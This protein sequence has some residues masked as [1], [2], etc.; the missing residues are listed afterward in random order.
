MPPSAF[1]ALS[2]KIDRLGLEIGIEAF[3]AAFPSNARLLISAKWRDRINLQA[4]DADI[5]RSHLTR[6]TLGPLDI[7]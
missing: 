2:G 4:I 5:A 1:L 7:L 6:D 3:G